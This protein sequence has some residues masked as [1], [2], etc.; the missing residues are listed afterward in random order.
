[1]QRMEVSQSKEGSQR[2]PLCPGA[3]RVCLW[4]APNLRIHQ[5]LLPDLHVWRVQRDYPA[6][7]PTLTQ[8]SRIKRQNHVEQGRGSYLQIQ[9]VLQLWEPPP[10]VQEGE[11]CGVESLPFRPLP[12]GGLGAMLSMDGCPSEPLDLQ[13]QCDAQ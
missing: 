10:Q 3:V 11:C 8:V 9:G 12:C 2:S 6:C 5:T 1:M 13:F 7:N 4:C